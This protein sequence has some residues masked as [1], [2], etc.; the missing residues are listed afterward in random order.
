ADAAAA[1]GVTS[2]VLMPDTTPVIDD[3]ALVDFVL[4]RAGAKASVNVLPAAALTRGLRGEELT[5]YG[6]LQEAGAVALTDGRASIQSAGLLRAAFGYA[7]NFDMPVIHQPAERSLIGDG[8]MN[9]GL[10]ASISGL[11]GIPIEAETIPL[12][13]DLQLAALTDVR[14]H[15]AQV[16]TGAAVELLAA[17][18]RRSSRVSAGISINNLSLNENDVAPYRTF[19]KLAPPLRSEDDR[20]A[21]IDGLVSGAIDTIHSAHD[22]QDTEVKRQ[23]FAEASDG[24]I[25]LETLLAAA[26]RLVHS[27]DVPLLT[28]LRAMTSRPAE[29][30]GLSSGRL[31]VGAPADLIV[32][33]PDFPWVVTEPGIRS[34]SRNTAFEGA[35]M[36]GA[37]MHSFVAGRPV[38][39][40]AAT[41]EGAAT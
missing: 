15:A 5:E 7:R 33:D 27:G 38:F 2:F 29:I 10:L 25:G 9:E 3:G 26:L 35:R 36:Q 14:Y 18:K 23:P 1:G 12:A 28:I 22:P 8:V 39:S 34:R 24:A 11:K 13:R 17:A 32:F 21:V 31:A 37:V 41:R 30:L 16:S 4:R 6:L 20:R 40:H 19:F